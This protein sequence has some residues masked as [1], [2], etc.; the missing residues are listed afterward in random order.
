MS[1]DKPESS[2]HSTAPSGPA[3]KPGQDRLAAALRDNLKRRKAQARA[4]RA[5]EPSRQDG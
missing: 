2:K 5:P 4:R 1:S 3:R